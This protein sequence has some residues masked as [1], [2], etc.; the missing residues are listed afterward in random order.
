MYTVDQGVDCV[1]VCVGAWWRHENSEGHLMYL[2]HSA[3]TSLTREHYIIQEVHSVMYTVDPWLE[4]VGACVWGDDVMRI[5]KVI[6]C[7]Y[8]TVLTHHSPVNII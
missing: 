5:V 6:Y 3:H 4:C 7:T 2:H 1:G 8:T